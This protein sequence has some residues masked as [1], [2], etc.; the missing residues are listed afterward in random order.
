[1]ARAGI[2][3]RVALRR[4]LLGF[5]KEVKQE[6]R[7]DAVEAALVAGIIGKNTGQNTI[8]TTPS[9]LSIEPKGNRI[10]TGAM[11]EDFDADVTQRGTSIIVKVGW[12]KR[13]RKYYGVQEHGGVVQ[14]RRGAIT[15]SGMHAITN[16][17][18]AV[19]RHLD[20]KGIR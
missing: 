14:T 8:A 15:V 9:D 6:T 5:N 10:W 13:K 2:E 7:K 18:M 12:L 1:M 19:Q 16:A 11:Y 4:G 3:G 20:N 17:T